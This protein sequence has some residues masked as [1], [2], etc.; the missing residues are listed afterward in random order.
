MKLFETSALDFS[1][2]AR[3]STTCSGG[4]DEADCDFGLTKDFKQ[5]HYDLEVRVA[6]L[7]MFESFFYNRSALPVL[8]LL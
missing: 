8:C 4:I 1:S 2:S 6:V 5:D 3:R 7:R